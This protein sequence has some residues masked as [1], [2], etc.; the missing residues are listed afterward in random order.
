IDGVLAWSVSAKRNA[1]TRED[2]RRI[3]SLGR[4]LTCVLIH[5]FAIEVAGVEYGV[6]FAVPKAAAE[7]N[8]GAPLLTV[9]LF[10]QTV[11]GVDL[12]P[13]EVI[14]QDEVDHARYGV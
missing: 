11:L 3:A 9:A 7:G 10:R 8:V 14:L 5:R 6:A 2:G 13:F 1:A 12:H 4:E